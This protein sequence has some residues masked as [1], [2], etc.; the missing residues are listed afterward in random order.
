VIAL[1]RRAG[2]TAVA[3]W[4]LQRDGPTDTATATPTDTGTATAMPT[5]PAETEKIAALRKELSAWFNVDE[6]KVIALMKSLS[7]AEVDSVLGD[8]D[9]K[10][11]TAGC[12]DDDELYG[13]V[14]AMNGDP[15]KSLQWLKDTQTRYTFVRSARTELGDVKLDPRLDTAVTDLVQ[16]LLD[17]YMVKDDVSFDGIG[18]VR[19]P[20]TAHRNSTAYHIRT[21]VVTMDA[22][23]A[24][25]GGRDQDG[26]LW[27]KEGWTEA[28]AKANALAVWDGK[29]ANEGY[30]ADDP[31]RLP[32]A[33]EVPVSTH[34]NGKAMDVTIPWRDG[35]GWHPEARELVSRFGLV[36][37]FDPDERWHFELP[38]ASQ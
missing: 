37:P 16:H 35:D 32:N 11:K 14:R 9:I 17:H 10:S 12:L 25:P 31:R 6:G 3:R 1:Q 34:C 13:V 21:D 36:R 38:G 18:G 20:K 5:A 7:P 26:N 19:E 30:A 4:L 8:A 23:K 27:F 15:V 33:A 2:N 22:L 24:L 29:V 28:Q